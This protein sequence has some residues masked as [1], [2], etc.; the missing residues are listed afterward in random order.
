MFHFSQFQR[1]SGIPNVRPRSWVDK[2][3]IRWTNQKVNDYKWG[4]REPGVNMD[5]YNG[6]PFGWNDVK[7]NK[8]FFPNHPRK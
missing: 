2:Y 7:R 1:R 5:E 4:E 8:I 3:G 6:G